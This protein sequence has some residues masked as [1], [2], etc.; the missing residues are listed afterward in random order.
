M[1]V[2]GSKRNSVSEPGGYVARLSTRGRCGVGRGQQLLES[3][4]FAPWVYSSWWSGRSLSVSP[5]FLIN[6]SNYSLRFI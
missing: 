5:A 2:F 6:V 1:L 4:S 3:I